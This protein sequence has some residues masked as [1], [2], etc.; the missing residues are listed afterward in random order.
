L[1]RDAG[2]FGLGN[3]GL[4]GV[5]RRRTPSRTVPDPSTRQIG[6]S[7]SAIRSGGER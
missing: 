2:V 3:M 5:R 7:R 1:S 4:R 6:T